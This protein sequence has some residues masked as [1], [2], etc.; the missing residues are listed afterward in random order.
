MILVSKICQILDFK[1]K[2]GIK[3][4]NNVENRPQIK[5][6]YW[7]LEI[8]RIMQ[9]KINDYQHSY[10]AVYKNANSSNPQQQLFHSVNHDNMTNSFQ[11]RDHESDTESNNSDEQLFTI[12]KINH[13]LKLTCSK[14]AQPRIQVLT[15]IRMTATAFDFPLIV[16]GSH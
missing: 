11:T 7:F 5:Q 9:P 16:L 6:I 1:T 10:R 14:Q 13:R 3:M 4:I 2:S 8:E 15:Q 12:I